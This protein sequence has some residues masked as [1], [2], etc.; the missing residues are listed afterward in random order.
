MSPKSYNARL[1]LRFAKGNNSS[2][3]T[4]QDCQNLGLMKEKKRKGIIL[5]NEGASEEEI[6]KTK[7]TKIEKC[8]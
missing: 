5:K 2:P 6:L 7:R 3:L 8:S 1:R 4:N